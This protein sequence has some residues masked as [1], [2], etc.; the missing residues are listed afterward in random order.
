MPSHSF[1]ALT[2]L[3]VRR[4]KGDVTLFIHCVNGLV[5]QPRLACASRR[6]PPGGALACALG[7]GTLPHA[8]VVRRRKGG[9]ALFIHCVNDLID[10]PGL[11]VPAVARPPEG[12]WRAHSAAA[13]C[14]TRLLCAAE[15]ILSTNHG[16]PAPAA[17]RPPAAS[18]PSVPVRGYNVRKASRHPRTSST[19]MIG[20][21]TVFHANISS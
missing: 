6:T 17:A 2:A 18:V 5:D 4:V 9:V 12:H 13:P 16:L 14:R 1:A 20:A 7:S 8:L 3:V 10:Q 21:D 15:M 19:R 11:P